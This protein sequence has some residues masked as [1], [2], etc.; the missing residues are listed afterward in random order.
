MARKRKGRPKRRAR[1]RRG[2]L[3]RLVRGLFM[4]GLLLSLALVFALDVVV[5]S[6]FSGAKWSL[7]SHVYS[8]ALEL[9]EGLSLRQGQLVWELEKLGYRKAST[10]T[11][12]G[13]YRLNGR[14]IDLRL[15][16]FQFWDGETASQ[17]IR[18]KFGS[19]GVTELSNGRGKALALVRLEP[20]LIGGIYPEHREDREPV[21]LENLPPYLVESLIAVE[22]RGFYQHRGISWRGIARAIRGNVLSGTASQGG[23]TLT[24]QLV[25]NFY[26]SQD[27]TLLRKGIE[28]IMAVLL[29]LHYSKGEI[30]ET[31]INEIYLGQAGNRAIHGFGMASRHYFNQ[32]L[33]ELE[34]HQLALLTGLA[35]G[36]SYYAPRRHPERAL[37]RR[38]LVIT[39]LKNQQLVDPIVAQNAS[40]K[41]L[42]LSAHPGTKTQPF[43]AYLDF[44]KR[45]LRE[46]YVEEELRSEGLRIFTSFDPQVQKSVEENLAR[47]LRDIETNRR[48]EKNTLQAGVVV[49]RVGT[50]EVLA[51]AGSRQS[52]FAGFNRALDAH[53]PIG[54]TVKP[55]VY[56]A[57]LQQTDKFTLATLIDDSSMRVLTDDGSVWEPR[58]FDRKDHGDVPL[59][60]AIGR[61]YNQATVRVGMA[62]GLVEVADT[63]RELGYQRVIPEVPALIL[64]AIT[65]S[66]MELASIY[67][68]IASDG[69]YTPLGAIESVYTPDNAPLQKYYHRSTPRFDVGVM[70]LLHYAMQVVMREGTG[71]G[72]Y[73]IIPK[74]R[75]LL[76]KTGTSNDQRDSWFAGFGGNYL[77]VVWLGR[78][79]NGAMPLTGSSGALKVWSHIMNDV[80]VSSFT[81]TK[82]DNVVYRWTDPASG[83]LSKKKCRGARYLPYLEGSA[84]TT[85]A[86]CGRDQS[87]A[88]G[89]EIIDWLKGVFQ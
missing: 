16:P 22:D 63:I 65:M 18:I 8:R 56:L 39:L 14:V 4:L 49:V 85:Y 13:Q 54:S 78:D 46:D 88:R 3:S 20:Q 79:D 58:N 83:L 25:K 60:Q 70:H 57:A 64:G 1:R 62:L 66:P 42:G 55:A 61:S 27:R 10:I 47:D 59:Y 77:G 68:T 48:L 89:V 7:P 31:Y 29:E 37:K 52:G 75:I 69:F 36:A 73:K 82:P 34:L 71:K 5:R 81:F 9:Y 33:A 21:R 44:I 87:R 2:L 86:N 12:P 17:N 41:A 84:P 80:G 11:S 74:D 26:L 35:K 53:R 51:V 23:S 43:P 32:P 45:Q 38:N 24:Q 50:G 15:R 67:H 40:A 6:K 76:G 30:L 72:A 28:A 19:K